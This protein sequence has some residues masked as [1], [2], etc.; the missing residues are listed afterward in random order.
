MSYS[1]AYIIATYQCQGSE[2]LEYQLMCL[3]LTSGVSL[4]FDKGACLTCAQLQKAPRVVSSE[5][6]K[7]GTH[8]YHQKDILAIVRLDIVGQ[9]LEIFSC[10]SP[11]LCRLL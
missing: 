6:D 1:L 11:D 8:H 9:R 5:C 4:T 3:R 2:N 7:A 10:K